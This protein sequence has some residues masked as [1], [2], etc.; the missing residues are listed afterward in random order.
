MTKRRHQNGGLRKVCGCPRRTWPKCRHG[1]HLNYKPRGGPAYRLSLDVEAGTH[2]ASKTE[3]AKLANTIRTQ[4]DDGTFRRRG[5]A[6]PRETSPATADAITLTK[7]GETYFERRD[8]RVT[9][10]DRSYLRRL[11]AAVVDDTSLGDRQIGLLTTD[12]FETFFASLRQA[13]FAP[14]TL[15]KYRH[16]VSGLLRWAVKKQYLG[17]NPL[18]GAE[19]ITHVS[20]KGSRRSR[21]LEPDRVEDDG[22]K[23]PGEEARLLAAAGPWLQR[24]IIGALESGMRRGELLQ[25]TWRD[26]DLKRRELIVRA[27]T[28]KTRTLR[29][30]PISQRLAAVLEMARLDPHGQPFGPDA[31]V[32]GDAIGRRVATPKKS[33][34]SATLRAHGYVPEWITGG[35]LS[36][37]S[38]A[39]LR[40]IDLHFHD[41]RHEAGSRFIEAGWPVHHVASM[42]GHADLKQTST[43]LN[44]TRLGLQ[45]SMRRFIDEP[46]ARCNPVA[47]DPATEPQPVCNTADSPAEKLLVN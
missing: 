19:T 2:L 13:G 33:W 4:I 25:L 44:V 14:S 43:Y 6:P 46:S 5:D 12:L 28:S 22:T 21:R 11:C 20:E 9:A 29:R 23:H 34:E 31:F 39:A 35:K 37:A 42:L 26:V 7:L 40:R 15:N 10:N 16:F 36:T 38:R 30:L 24:L 45:E 8:T 27:A 1:W 17:R 18:D 3:A 41:L 32:F 47:N